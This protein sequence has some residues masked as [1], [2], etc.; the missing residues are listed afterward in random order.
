MNFSRVERDFSQ[1][2]NHLNPYIDRNFSILLLGNRFTMLDPELIY[3][4]SLTLVPNIGDVQARI[5]VQH[6]GDASAIFKAKASVLEKIEGIG[7]VRANSI[8]GFNEF[9]LAE[10]EINFIEKYRIRPLF[11]TDPDYPRR[12]LNCY[13]APTLL[14]YKGMA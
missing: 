13:D 1:S 12:L 3:R 4:L 14:F 10:A 8:K 11:L 9:H 2:W 7:S 5:L 6:F